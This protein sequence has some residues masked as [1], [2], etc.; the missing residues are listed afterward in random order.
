MANRVFPAPAWPAS[1]VA[2]PRGNPP[3]ES[4]SK[5]AMPVGH[6]LSAEACESL[7]ERILHAIP[8]YDEVRCSS[9]DSTPL[10][11]PIDRGAN[12][13]SKC[14]MGGKEGTVKHQ[15]GLRLCNNS[16]IFALA[17]LHILRPYRYLQRASHWF[18]DPLFQNSHYRH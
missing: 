8:Y 6:F 4:S 9:L 18:V 1:K 2:R 10:P 3:S 14:T 5:P 11:P 17:L 13:T 12:S 16:T 7:M 15:V